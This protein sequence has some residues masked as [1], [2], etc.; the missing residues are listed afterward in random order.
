MRKVSYLLLKL[1]QMRITALTQVVFAST[2]FL[3]TAPT[4]VINKQ[5]LSKHWRGGLKIPPLFFYAIIQL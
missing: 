4:T 5:L 1:R 2:V 3:A